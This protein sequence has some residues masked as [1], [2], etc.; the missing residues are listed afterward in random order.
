MKTLVVYFSASGV[1]KGVAN[2][3]ASKLNCDIYEIKPVV[4]YTDKNLNWMDKNSRS[5]LEMK[6]KS[7]RPEIITGDIDV[8]QY[9][10]I[11]LGYPVWWYT[12]PTIVNTFLEAYDFS[13]KEI[14]IWATSGGSGLG[15]AKD[16]LAKSTTAKII[17]GKKL[18][19]TA[20]LEQ[21]I[22][23]II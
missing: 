13:D 4:P 22:K 15:K 12:A 19:T 11:L 20:Q 5:T 1:T 6:D 18:N 8:S 16:D 17:N 14:I 10:R 23:E 21:F 7:S 2:K 3:L 9:D